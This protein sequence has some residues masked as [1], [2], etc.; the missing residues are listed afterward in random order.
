MTRRATPRLTGRRRWPTCFSLIFPQY[1][2]VLHKVHV[3]ERYSK[4]SKS[5]EPLHRP[6]ARR[7]QRTVSTSSRSRSHLPTRSRL[8]KGQYR[9]NHVPARELSGSI[10]QAEKY[11]FYLSKSGRDGERK[12]HDEAQG[13]LSPPALMSRSPTPRPSSSPGATTTCR[14]RRSSTSSSPD[15]STPTSSTSSPMT[16]CCVGWTTSSPP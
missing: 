11:L 10:M 12:H 14:R 16:T 3:T 1:V 9:G 15:G 5:T 4:E 13:R 6:H 7:R 8:A 2:A